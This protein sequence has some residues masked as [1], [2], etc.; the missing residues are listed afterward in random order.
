TWMPT[1]TAKRWGPTSTPRDR[2]SNQLL[3]IAGSNPRTYGY[4]AAGNVLSDG[5]NQFGYDEL[6][7]LV[8]VSN[9]KGIT[10]YAINGLGQRVAKLGPET[11]RYFVYDEAG[12]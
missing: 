1:V 2:D 4:D 8:A 3:S 5:G 7:R 12:R 6:G 11:S 10:Q 9:D